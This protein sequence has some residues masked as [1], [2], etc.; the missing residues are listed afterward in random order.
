MSVDW[1]FLLPVPAAI[2]SDAYLEV[3]ECWKGQDYVIEAGDR[4]DPRLERDAKRRRDVA[5]AFT[6]THLIALQA[7]RKPRDILVMTDAAAPDE[8]PRTYAQ[9]R[10][11]WLEAGAFA[12]P[13][14]V[15]D[16]VAASHT[17][18]LTPA[19]VRIP[20]PEGTVRARLRRLD[21]LYALEQMGRRQVSPEGVRAGVV[22]VDVNGT[23][24]AVL[25]KHYR[26][27]CAPSG[28]DRGR[29]SHRS[30]SKAIS[31]R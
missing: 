7:S 6:S 23:D 13:D 10:A 14:V 12:L 18:P 3:D 15:D 24:L 25:A 9:I 30:G 22:F 4:W 20:F 2:L 21:A 28:C 8:R 17:A 11:L 5:F 27:L 19:D 16:V 26:K 31:C 29:T 1:L